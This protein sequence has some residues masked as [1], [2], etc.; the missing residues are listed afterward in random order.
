MIKILIADDHPFTL[1][2]TKA[3]VEGIGHNVCE[4]CSNGISAY[5]M[6]LFH[7]PEIA[8]LDFGMPGMSGID[9]LEKAR[10]TIPQTKIILLTMH[11]EHS[12]FK[13]ALSLGVKGYVLKEFATD[14]LDQCLSAVIKGNT[15]FSQELTENLKIDGDDNNQDS[16]NLLNV[17]SF[18]EKKVIA[19]IA[20]QRSSKEIAGMLFISEK[21]V[22]N[23]RSN[24]IKK[25]NLP[26]EKNALLVWALK[27][28]IQA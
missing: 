20:Q 9:I 28:H 4:I 17:L 16:S 5:N 2:G 27:N 26:S 7:K 21:T 22:E 10:V 6:M 3:Y 11:K 12:L 14:V 1:M 24:I 19:L 15:W 13:R 25:L 18:A 8:I 23:H